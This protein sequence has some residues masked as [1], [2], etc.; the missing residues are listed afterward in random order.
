MF[1]HKNRVVFTVF[2]SL[3]LD[4]IFVAVCPHQG[5]QNKIAQDAIL[6]GAKGGAL[7]YRIS[8]RA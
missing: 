5:E 6:V 1:G 8:L 4:E 7:Q 2:T 3:P